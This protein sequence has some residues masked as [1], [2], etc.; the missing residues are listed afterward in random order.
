MPTT[1]DKKTSSKKAPCLKFVFT[2]GGTG[3]HVIP[4]LAIIAEL[5][6]LA[7]KSEIIYIGEKNSIEERLAKKA[8]LNFYTVSTGKLRRYFSVQNLTD[9]LRVPLGIWQALRL[10]RKQKP[11]AVFTKGGYVSVPTAVAA[12]LLKIPLII[13]ESD[14]TPGLATKI[15]SRFAEKICV[16][17][18]K[19]K[20]FLPTGKTILT[21]NPIRPLGS[22][23]AGRKFLKF[24]NRKPIILVTGGSTGAQFLNQLIAGIAPKIAEK[25]NLV[26][27]T[28]PGKIT[29]Y[30]FKI[31]NLKIFDYLGSEY[32]DVLSA[33]DLVIAR[34]GANTIF[35]LA[36]AGKPSV[37]IPLPTA[38]SR[39][40]QILNAEFFSEAGAS[41][42]MLQAEID[43]AR[44]TKLILGLIDDKIRLKK[45]GSAAK[46]L[47]PKNATQKIAKLI[48]E[49]S[50]KRLY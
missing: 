21:G 25:A 40:D 15:A 7:P 35:E 37:L 48:L 5:K 39:G 14:F 44:F 32:P 38:G 47:A 23:A 3:G 34:A 36:D 16:S 1:F 18:A 45:M 43:P 8:K 27:L 4:C 33:T 46:K 31:K 42:L 13:H 2:G 9:A 12:G 49:I 11:H 28:G 22:S 24:G 26:W 41:K 30:K 6:K 19:T 50:S 10:L 17:F 20:E 29:N